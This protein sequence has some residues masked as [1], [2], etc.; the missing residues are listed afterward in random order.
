[1]SAQGRPAE[2]PQGWDRGS[3]LSRRL[4]LRRRVSIRR[5][6]DEAVAFVETIRDR[7]WTTSTLKVREARAVTVL[8]EI[9]A[10]KVAPLLVSSKGGA[11]SAGGMPLI[12]RWSPD[13]RY[14]AWGS[15]KEPPYN[16]HIAERGEWTARTLPLVG[17]WVGE[18]A[19]SPDG[20][21]LAISTYAENRTDHTIL[22]HDILG[23]GHPKQIAKGCV[24]V[25]SPDSRHLVLHGEPRSQPGLWV[26]S[27]DG[28]S[29]RIS[30]RAAVAPF[31]WVAE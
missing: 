1:M 8:G 27:V 9:A 7:H 11:R 12:V 18:L 14:V 26:V 31:V 21:Y 2:A 6:T 10:G 20:R 23:D 15:V 3:S 25:W 22:V 29:W 13:G 30:E 17:G 24:M 4:R 5:R 19:W 28:E 16:L